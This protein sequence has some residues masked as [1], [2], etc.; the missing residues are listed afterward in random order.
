MD[1][2]R[3]GNLIE[4]AVWAVMA[5][6]AFWKASTSPR[7]FRPTLIALAIT[8]AIFG[9]SDLVEARTGAWWRPWWLLVW[10]GLCVLT[11]LALFVKYFRLTRRLRASDHKDA[12]LR[13]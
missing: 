7:I 3:D 11:L 9:A 1:L 13:S 8:L 12:E 6:A 10:K 5:L 4:A 2:Q